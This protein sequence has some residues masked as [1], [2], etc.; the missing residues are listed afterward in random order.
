MTPFRLEQDSSRKKKKLI[1]HY[2]NGCCYLGGNV[3]IWITSVDQSAV[4]ARLCDWS[5]V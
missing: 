3:G 5:T 1:G 4:S 2:R